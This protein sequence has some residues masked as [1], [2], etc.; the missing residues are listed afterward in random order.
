MVS[1]D[2]QALANAISEAVKNKQLRKVYANVYT[3]NLV[4]SL[5]NIVAQ[6][7][8]PI[9]GALYPKAVISHRSAIEAGPKNNQIFLTYKYTKKVSLPGMVVHL[10]EGPEPLA[11]D[12]PFVSGL[13]LACLE[14][15]WLENYQIARG[16]DHRKTLSA[17]E[18]E[19]KLE[20]YLRNYGEE[21]FK[22][23]IDRLHRL[24]EQ[25]NLQ[26]SAKRFQ[27]VAGALLNTRTPKY[28]ISDQ[29]K[30]RARGLPYD[31]DRLTRFD[32]LFRY[33]KKNPPP[34]IPLPDYDRSALSNLSFFDAYFSNYIEGTRFEVN[35]AVDI[36][37]HAK[38]PGNRP[39]G[40]D[41]AGTYSALFALATQANFIDFNFEQLAEFLKD[42]HLVLM[43][44]HEDKNPGAFKTKENRAGDVKFVAP[45]LV[46]GTL[47]RGYEFFPSLDPGFP[48]ATY[49]KF[50][51]A[52]IH[53]FAD[54]NGRISR[55][56]LNRELYKDR[57]C[58]IIIPTVY[59]PDY[60]GA[61]KK[62]TK[63]NDP[64]AF[65]RM[66]ARA[67][68]FTARINFE[69]FESAHEQLR[70]YKAFSDDPADVLRF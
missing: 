50:L 7:L 63:S 60:M 54:G 51:I 8:Y 9:L 14:R 69:T 1:S 67:Q 39:E 10:L 70:H 34:R 53:P 48:R 58:P 30:Q 3:D 68:E 19:K 44:A 27:K 65:V 5:E 6:N 16:S 11:D 24:S 21:K 4:D 26:D 35:E 29:G 18:M 12:S 46:E 33:L 47:K 17:E 62:L 42:R 40:H 28:L 45:G 37:Y 41:I 13:Y 56:V 59:R 57:Q 25:M 55:I 20:E 49:L 43:R 36:V 38:I 15:S 64:A 31:P 22:E 66:L 52:E 61:V 2:N 32:A 23:R